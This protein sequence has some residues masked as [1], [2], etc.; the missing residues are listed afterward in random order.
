MRTTDEHIS[1][2]ALHSER[3][4]VNLISCIK[5]LVSITYHRLKKTYTAKILVHE[6]L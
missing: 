2:A 5:A 4:K 1:L 6:S 3:I